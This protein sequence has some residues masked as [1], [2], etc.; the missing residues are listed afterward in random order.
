MRDGNGKAA[1]KAKSGERPANLNDENGRLSASAFGNVYAEKKI[2]VTGH[3]GLEG[4]WLC[5]WL[6]ALGADVTG[7]RSMSRSHRSF[8]TQARMA[9]DRRDAAMFAICRS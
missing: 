3:T 6:L 9:P 2:L 4:A 8:V 5:E 1:P 7:S